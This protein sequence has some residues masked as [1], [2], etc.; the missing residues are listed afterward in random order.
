MN[1]K[2]LLVAALCAAMNLS[3]FAQTNLALNKTV[4]KVGTNVEGVAESLA[5]LTDGDLNGDVQLMPTSSSGIQG[6][7]I[8]LGETAEIGLIKITWEG[9]AAAKY[10]IF[11]SENGSDWTP[12]KECDYA[13]GAGNIRKTDELKLEDGT[14]AR[15]IKFEAT[16][17]IVADWGVK[18]REFQVFKAEAAV[19][20]SITTSVGFVNKNEATDL[21]LKAADQFKADFSGKVTYTTDNGT[22]TDGKLTATAGG[23]CT[24]T[25]TDEK[26]NTATTTVYVLDDSMAPTKPTASAENAYGIYSSY[27][28]DKFVHWMTWSGMDI[29]QEELTLGGEKVKPLSG[30]N[31]I[32]IGQKANEADQGEQWMNFDNSTDKFT[33]LSMDVFPSTDFQGTL[34]I[35]G[36]KGNKETKVNLEAGKW[37]TIELTGIEGEGNI[38]KCV[39]L[40]TEGTFAPMLISNIYLYKLAA[41]QVVVSPTANTNGFY[42]VSGNITAKNVAELKKA[43][44]T[45]FDLTGANIAED[46]KKIEFANPNALIMVAGNAKDFETANKLTETN[47]VITTDGIYFFAANTLKFNDATPINTKISIDTSKGQSTGYEYTREIAANAW[48]TTTPLTGADAPEGVEA[49]ELDTENSKAN[50][51]VFKKATNLVAGTPYVLHNTTS[52]EVTLKVAA[53]TGDYNP[54]IAPSAVAAANVTFHGNYAA[55]NGTKAEYGLQNA[56][57][58]DDNILTFKK[59]GEGA[60]IGTFRAYFTLNDVAEASS[61]S[62]HFPG[63][64]TTGINNVNVVNVAKKTAGVYTLDGRKVSEGNAISNLP[65]GIYIVNGKKVIK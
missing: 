61:L 43:E 39:G 59:V 17:A 42:T 46:V 13:E 25:A 48:V 34:S 47:N 16:T 6:F 40:A 3:A 65:K 41:D 11:G 35:E 64:G 44:G 52:E 15:Y 53:T 10:T 63:N 24:I 50:E 51:V 26:G 60:T 4:T 8:D 21:G 62:I 54:T 5:A 57:V 45:A 31:K 56:T 27:Q 22:I 37:N 7:E 23:P 32:V 12:I 2:F 29:S 9:A 1:K 33:T 36:S 20:S 38:I 55:K 58:G 19:L 14:K 49:Y 18:M 30:G 28:S